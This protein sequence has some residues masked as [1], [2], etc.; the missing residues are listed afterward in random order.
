MPAS[1]AIRLGVEGGAE[2]KRA[3]DDAGRAG[4]AAFQGVGAAADAA[5]AATDRQVAKFQRLAQAAREAEAQARAQANVNALLGVGAGSA[6]SARD[7]ASA[8]EDALARQDQ[9]EA[10]RRAQAAQN[11][12]T[13][14]NQV[15]G[16]REAQVGAA[17][18][19][20]G[21]FEDAYRQEAEALKRTADLR[22]AAIR[23]A[24][25]G[26]RDLSAA[27]TL[28]LANIEASRRLG[29]LGV[30]PQAANENARLR[31]D[32]VQNLL[33]QGGD[34]LAQVGSGSPLGMIAFQQGPQIAQTFAGPGGASVTGALTQAGEAVSSFVA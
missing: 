28:A 14:L 20:A 26:W 2:V 25:T 23:N 13:S 10:A 24:S 22:T 3:L 5:G 12:Q 6:G 34:V 18:A 15:L 7:S 31:P 17:R 21:A 19:S 8:F 29:S 30:G 27:G 4:Q 9:V 16:I 32:Q 33:Y 11:A 1:I